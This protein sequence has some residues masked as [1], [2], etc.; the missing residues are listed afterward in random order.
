MPDPGPEEDRPYDDVIGPIPL[1]LHPWK[2]FSNYVRYKSVILGSLA[3]LLFA[4]YWLIRQAFRLPDYSFLSEVCVVLAAG[5][6]TFLA[7]PVIVGFAA[8][9]RGLTIS[10]VLLASLLSAWIAFWH[11]GVLGSLLIEASV[12]L[13]L[14]AALEMLL[15]HF[16]EVVQKSYEEVKSRLDA[17]EAEED[18]EPP[19][20]P[21]RTFG[22]PFGEPDQDDFIVEDEPRKE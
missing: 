18:P 20:A 9:R 13:L 5:I 6:T 19:D 1:L 15:R 7:A 4:D 22:Y 3:V 8:K 11:E 21:E 10:V 14:L 12:A 2:Y 16:T 17:G